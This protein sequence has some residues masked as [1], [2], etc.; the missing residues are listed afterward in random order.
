MAID[1]VQEYIKNKIE[2]IEKLNS[3][4]ERI[5]EVLFAGQEE[6]EVK[7]KT[8]TIPL[9]AERVKELNKKIDRTIEEIEKM[10]AE[11]EYELVNRSLEKD[12][13]A[14][15]FVD[16]K[17]DELKKQIEDGK[18][19][20]EEYENFESKIE[21]NKNLKNINRLIK[22]RKDIIKELKDIEEKKKI[23]N[24]DIKF[25]QT[26]IKDLETLEE[27]NNKLIEENNNIEE[28]LKDDSLSKAEREK[29]ELKLKYNKEKI[30]FNKG[31]IK[32]SKEILNNKRNELAQKLDEKKIIENTQKQKKKEITIIE[33]NLKGLGITDLDDVKLDEIY[34]SN[35]PII[36][37]N[38]RTIANVKKNLNIAPEKAEDIEHIKERAKEET[39]KILKQIKSLEEKEEGIDEN[40]L[41]SKVKESIL[42][43]FSEIDNIPIE[44]V[45]RNVVE[46]RIE[47]EREERKAA[48]ANRNVENE[49]GSSNGTVKSGLPISLNSL[50]PPKNTFDI[51]V[52]FFQRIKDFF[53][54]DFRATRREIA[55]NMYPELNPVE[56]QNYINDHTK[57]LNKLVRGGTTIADVKEAVKVQEEIRKE[58]LDRIKKNKFLEKL[59]VDL[60][61]GK[62]VEKTIDEYAQ[63]KAKNALETERDE[64]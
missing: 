31:R 44:K 7:G 25:L 12:G 47:K 53:S 43:E 29:L 22:Y 33:N 38:T 6:K 57:G 64:M 36:N 18:K 56:L 20:V 19:E 30:E 50:R 11:I 27:Q 34:N 14:K 2:E 58:R 40:T 13:K 3:R 24:E 1:N 55:K 63:E 41:K 10:Q 4:I 49:K 32:D 16:K 28:Q 9:T 62:D 21:E 51:N 48:R 60:K 61:D 54:K 52:G 45:V 8:K 17:K 46:A 23:L 5:N 37:E 59:K 39:E 35:I 15:E 42:S 26:E